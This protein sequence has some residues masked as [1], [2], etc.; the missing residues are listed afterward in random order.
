MPLILSNF[1]LIKKQFID[2]VHKLFTTLY[3]KE[4]LFSRGILTRYIA[5][6]IIKVKI[7]SP[8]QNMQNGNSTLKQEV[9]YYQHY[10]HCVLYD[11]RKTHRGK[12]PSIAER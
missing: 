10:G 12:N 4:A 5:V 9:D 1:V 3:Q 6:V 8:H 7:I 2:F 11:Q